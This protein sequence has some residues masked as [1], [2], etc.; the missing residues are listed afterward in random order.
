MIDPEIKNNYKNLIKKIEIDHPLAEVLE[1]FVDKYDGSDEDLF[2]LVSF[3]M[4]NTLM[5][6]KDLTIAAEGFEAIQGEM[7]ESQNRIDE[8]KDEL[9]LFDEG[10]ENE[11]EPTVSDESQDE[12]APS[13]E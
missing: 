6:L 4:L 12:E 13:Q 9:K 1:Q 2:N 11:N 8:L 7:D 3:T 10:K 5:E